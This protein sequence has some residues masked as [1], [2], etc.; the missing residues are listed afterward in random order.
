MHIDKYD[1]GILAHLQRDARLTSNEL[2]SLVALSPSQCSR[3]RARLE[4]AGLIEGY[5][6][7]LSFEKLGYSMLV[8]IWVTLSP[9]NRENA[10]RFAEFLAD[11]PEVLEAHALSGDLDYFL[12]AATGD[13]DGLTRLVNDRLLAHETVSHVKTAIVLQ[14]LKGYQGLPV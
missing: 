12:K 13:L 1:T 8:M 6:A 4:K 11:V 3:R 7:E 2:A 10:R 14:T 9:H 5:R